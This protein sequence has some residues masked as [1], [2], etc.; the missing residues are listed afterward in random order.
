[1]IDG[2]MD[3]AHEFDPYVS[4]FHSRLRDL[5]ISF[6]HMDWGGFTLISPFSV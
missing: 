2:S 6:L 5:F 1:V 4:L 3:I